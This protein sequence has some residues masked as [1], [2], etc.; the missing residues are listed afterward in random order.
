MQKDRDRE[1][2]FYVFRLNVFD[3]TV[4]LNSDWSVGVVLG[5][6]THLKGRRQIVLQKPELHRRL[7][8]FQHRQHHYSKKNFI[9]NK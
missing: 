1:R 7:G 5:H 8:V 4:L 6:H 3:C 9:I 2:H